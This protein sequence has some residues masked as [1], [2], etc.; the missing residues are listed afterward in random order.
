MTCSTERAARAGRKAPSSKVNIIWARRRASAST[1][2][3]TDRHT[4]VIGSKTRLKD[5]VRSHGW[6]VESTMASFPRITFTAMVTMFTRMGSHTTVSLTKIRSKVSAS[7]CGTMGERMRAGGIKENN[8]DSE[9]TPMHP[10]KQ[11]TASGSV[12]SV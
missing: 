11:D 8:T 10:K 9:C 6:M 1:P 4:K 5:M 3:R 2:T 12:E 7:T